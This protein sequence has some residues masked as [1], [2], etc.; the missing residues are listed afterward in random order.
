MRVLAIVTMGNFFYFFF[1]FLLFALT[2]GATFLC[3]RLGKKFAYRFISVILWANF[4]LHF[5]KQFFPLYY[6]NWPYFLAESAFPNLCAFLIVVAPFVFHWGNKYFKD[7]LYF[8]GIISALVAYAV[9]TGPM[10][11]DIHGVDYA[12]ELTRYYLCHAPLVTCG[13]LMVEQGFHRLDWRRSWAI[14]IMFSGVLAVTC[15]DQILY[16]PILKLPGHPYEWVGE[17][18][19]L[20]RLSTGSGYAN[21]SMQFGPQSKVDPFFSWLYPYLIPGLMTYRVGGEIYFVPAIWIMP[22]IYLATFLI[23]P[24][25]TLPFE[26]KAM[27]MDVLA[28]RDKARL[29]RLH[30]RAGR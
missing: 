13:F 12:L 10:R 26:H 22:F 29:R 30:R 24:L 23:A 17:H 27:R 11:T 6:K 3:H 9:P 15:L 18:G 16:G 28:W 19:I 21:Q 5:L 20:N 8:I 14:P 1:I 2:A 7:Y 4:A 25:M